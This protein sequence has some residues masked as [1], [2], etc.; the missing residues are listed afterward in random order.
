MPKRDTYARSALERITKRAGLPVD[1]PYSRWHKLRHTFGTHAA[2]FGVNPWTLMT[3]MG[4][5][6]I[7]ETMRY[8]HVAHAHR[9]AT[10]D[11]VL[12]AAQ[13]ETDPDLRVLL[14]L[15]ARKGVPPSRGIQVASNAFA[16]A[17]LVQ[18]AL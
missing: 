10:P 11:V 6:T 13:R 5:K 2:M 12:S 15:G 7:T 1:M 9:R 3:W 18:T 8:V 16:G 17:S 4:H 14:M